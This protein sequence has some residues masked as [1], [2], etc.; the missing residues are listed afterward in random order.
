MGSNSGDLKAH[1]N[2]YSGFTAMMKWGTIASFL[3]GAIV[4]LIISN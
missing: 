4:V 3:V 2:T 1:E